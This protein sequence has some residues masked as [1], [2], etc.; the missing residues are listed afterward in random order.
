MMKTFGQALAAIGGND[1]ITF[2]RG[3]LH[4]RMLAKRLEVIKALAQIKPADPQ[5]KDVQEDL[6]KLLETSNDVVL[7]IKTREA[8]AQIGDPRFIGKAPVVVSIPQQRRTGIKKLPYSFSRAVDYWCFVKFHYLRQQLP[9][10]RP[11]AIGKYPVTNIEYARFLEKTRHHTP[12]YWIEGTYPTEKATHPVTGITMKDAKAYCAWLSQETGKTY[13]LP[14]EWE[15]EWAATGPQGWKYPWGNQFLRNKCNTKEAATRETTP[16]GSY[17]YGTNQYGLTD[18]TGN[19]WE[20]T[21]GYTPSNSFFSLLLL[22]LLFL[23]IFLLP[24]FFSLTPYFLLILLALLILLLRPSLS[25]CILRGGAFDTVSYQ[26]TCFFRKRD[27]QAA[28]NV[29]FRCVKEL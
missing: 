23:P 22:F 24:L 4:S 6:V 9:H 18:M 10:K 5:I 13:R 25:C 21:Q 14:T 3:Q 15:W 17:L 16:V 7:R 27:Q 11:F 12:K 2:L 20:I 8:L 29:G 1:A 28:K 19:V 26:A